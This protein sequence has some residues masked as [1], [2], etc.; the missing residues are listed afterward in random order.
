MS[1]C[2]YEICIS[3]NMGLNSPPP[4]LNNVKK[5][6]YSVERESDIPTRNKCSF[7]FD[8]ISIPPFEYQP[9]FPGSSPSK[10]PR[11]HFQ[12]SSSTNSKAQRS[13]YCC[14]SKNS[15]NKP[16][17]LHILAKYSQNQ[18]NCVTMHHCRTSIA[19]ILKRANARFKLLVKIALFFAVFF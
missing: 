13:Y 6:C 2:H 15:D 17:F 19:S 7:E 14:S 5:N 11:E 10:I 8:W 3:F 12:L 18:N 9:Q 16:H 1:K 4:P